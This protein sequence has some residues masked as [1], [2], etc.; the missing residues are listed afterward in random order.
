[1][2]GVA[3][4]VKGGSVLEA[5]FSL[6]TEMSFF[7]YGGTNDTDEVVLI[8][9]LGALRCRTLPDA[10]LKGGSVSE[11]VLSFTYMTSSLATKETIER[12]KKKGK[13]KRN[14]ESCLAG[15]SGSYCARVGIHA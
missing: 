7:L 15:D 12:S 14:R 13:K 6:I 5:L 1:M 11:E 8:E 2:P 4:A 9:Q 3:A 10:A